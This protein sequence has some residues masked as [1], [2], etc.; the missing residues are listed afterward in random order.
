MVKGIDVRI[1]QLSFGYGSTPVLKA[2]LFPNGGTTYV[3]FRP[4]PDNGMIETYRHYG[5]VTQV[6]DDLGL[7]YAKVI[8]T[9]PAGTYAGDFSAEA[10]Q[11]F[12]MDY[13]LTTYRPHSGGT[14][15]SRAFPFLKISSYARL[16]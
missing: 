13:V 3:A 10:I 16:A 11:E 5:A 6:P 14:R 15:I 2:A 9:L 4:D 12:N 1:S 7:V 8:D